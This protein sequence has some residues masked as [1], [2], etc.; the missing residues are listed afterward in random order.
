MT[1]VVEPAKA[2]NGSV[3]EVGDRGG[4]AEQV[5]ELLARPGARCWGGARPGVGRSTRGGRG[6]RPRRAAGRGGP[7]RRWR[8]GSGGRWRPRRA[9]PRAAGPRGCRRPAAP[10]GRS[11]KIAGPRAR[12]RRRRARRPC[13]RARRGRPPRS[14]CSACAARVSHAVGG[15]TSTSRSKRSGARTAAWSVVAQ[16][17][18]APPT[19]TRSRPSSSSS[20]EQVG[21][22]LRATRRRRDRRVRR[23][24]RGRRRRSGR[25]GGRASVNVFQS[26]S[27]RRSSLARLLVSPWPHTN[28]GPVAEDG[29]G[30][31]RS[32][33]PTVPAPSHRWRPC[34]RLSPCLRSDCSVPA[35]RQPPRLDDERTERTGDELDDHD[36][37]ED[38]EWT[39]GAPGSVTGVEIVRSRLTGDHLHRAR[40]DRPAAARRRAGGVR[41]V[42]RGARPASRWERVVLRRCRMSGL[43]AA[44]LA[45]HRR[46]RSTDCKADQAWLR[47]S[48]LDRCE[49][50]DTDLRGAD[51]YGARV[52]RSAFRRCDLTEVDVSRLAVRAGV[53]PRLDGR[54]AQGRRVAA[55]PHDRQR[56]ARA[57]RAADPGGPRHH[58]RR[59]RA[60]SRRRR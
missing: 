48:V 57:A 10:A 23:S 14:Y 51:L 5:L 45:G 6:R 49:L 60:R 17:I 58:R 59:R 36:L 39:G 30:E 50:V 21:G 18:E 16:P 42:R 32:R 9:A 13:P 31:R 35:R 56:P 24:H 7:A 19:S 4:P 46:A 11:A 15:I 52:T 53:A 27:G 38:V 20:A 44:E 33:P 41:A 43:V 34:A 8:R 54:P 29:V 12:R 26:S 2:P 3:E 47:A 25:P 28:A 1:G 22:E 55:G 40:A 37:L